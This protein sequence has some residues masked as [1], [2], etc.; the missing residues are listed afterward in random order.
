MTTKLTPLQRAFLTLEETRSRLADVEASQREPIAIVGIGCRF[1]GSASDPQAYWT[2]LD[3]E[4][5]AVSTVPVT[6]WNHAPYLDG[7]STRPGTTY[8]Q[9]AGFLAMPV[10]EFDAAFFG[11]SPREA[12]AMDPQQRLLLEVAWEAL[13]HAGIAPDRLVGSATGVFVGI[14]AADYA[15]LQLRGGTLADIDAHYA[16][17]IA[18]SIASGRLS[19]LMGLQGPSLAIDTACSSSL[20][21][22]HL[23][24]QSLRARESDTALAAGVNLILSPESFIAFSRTHMLA[25]DGR[26]KVFDDAADGF[27]RG[28]GCGVVILKRLRDAVAQGDRVLAVVRGSAANQDGASASLTAPSGPAQEAVIRQ[29]LA[30][31]QLTPGDVQFVE[32]H[33]TGTSLG[34][35]IELRA[36]GAV[37]GAARDAEHALL[38]GSVKANVGHLEGAAGVA[39]LIKAVLALNARRVPGQLHVEHRTS[40]VNWD[41]LHLRLPARGGEPWPSVTTRRAAVSGFGFSGTNAHVILEEAPATSV[42]DPREGASPMQ[43]IPI[44]ARTP[45]AL[46]SLAAAY[47]TQLSDTESS[48]ADIAYTA[49]TGRAQLSGARSVVV[50]DD[51][52][53]ARTMLSAIAAGEHM[54]TAPPGRAPSAA[55]LFTG[56][57][58]QSARMGRAL[59]DAHPVFRDAIDASAVSLADVW[60]GVTLLDVLYGAHSALLLTDARYLQPAIVATELALAALWQAWGVEPVLLVG[61]SLGEYA[62]AAIA[63]VMTRHD[64]VR[65]VAERGRLMAELPVTASAMTSV[66]ADVASVRDALGASL[67][68]DVELAADNGPSQC[69]LTG[70]EPEIAQAE[71]RLRMALGVEPRRLLSTTNAFHSRFVEPMLDAF[72]AAAS[73]IQYAAPQIPVSW[74]LGAA[75]LASHDAP[76]ARYWRRQTRHAVQFG[77]AIAMLRDRGVTHAIEMGPHPV[78][79]GLV[80]AIDDR[81]LPIGLASLRRGRSDLETISAAVARWWSDGGRLDWVSFYAPARRSPIALPTY[82]FARERHWLEFAV[83]GAAPRITAARHPIVGTR[84]TSSALDAIVF[85]SEVSPD[86]LPL[87]D[88]HRIHAKATMPG[89]VWL[90]AMAVAGSRIDTRAHWSV[91]DL[92][93]HSPLQVDDAQSRVVQLVLRPTSPPGGYQVTAFSRDAGSPDGPWM[94]HADALLTAIA[95]AARPDVARD[96]TTSQQPLVVHR[97]AAPT[98]GTSPSRHE[99]YRRFAQVGLTLGAAFER[100]VSASQG[101]DCAVATIDAAG[102]PAWGYGIV[103]PVLVDACLQSI[104]LA[105]PDSA[106]GP[107]SLFMPLAVERFDWYGPTPA[108]FACETRLRPTA[109]HGETLVAD[110]VARDVDGRVIGELRGVTLKRARA[111]AL[112]PLSAAGARDSLYEVQWEPSTL[113]R[114]GDA[115]AGPVTPLTAIAERVAAQAPARAAETLLGSYAEHGPAMDRLAAQYVWRALE[116]MG[117]TLSVGDRIDAAALSVQLHVQPRHR[118]LFARF[119]DILVEDS[120]LGR[121]GDGYVVL[122]PLATA[123]IDR[124]VEAMRA[125]GT[126]FSGELELLVRCGE[127]LAPALTGDVDPLSLL[128][129]GGSLDAVHRI[130][131]DSPFPRTYNALVRDAIAALVA[132]RGTVGPLRVLEVGGGTG[133]T[134]AAV[135]EA[136]PAGG[137]EYLFT[138]ASPLFLAR[139]SERFAA[140]SDIAFRLFDLELDAE[141]QGY[142]AASFDLVVGANVIHATRDVGATLG[143]LHRLLA[144]GG[145][146]LMLEVVRPSRWVDLSFGFT[147]GWWAFADDFRATYPLL[148]ADAW[149]QVLDS[150]GFDE[151]VVALGSAGSGDGLEEQALLLARKPRAVAS[152]ESWIVLADRGGVGAALAKHGAAAGH[153]VVLLSDA[154]APA[155]AGVVHLPAPPDRTDS[156]ALARALS[157]AAIGRRV[158]GVVDLRALDAGSPDGTEHVG[159]AAIPAMAVHV[160]TVALASAQALLSCGLGA[161]GPCP[162]LWY[163]TRRGVRVHGADREPSLPQAT[164][165]GVSRTLQIEHPELQASCIDLADDGTEVVAN[166]DADADADAVVAALLDELRTASAEAQVALRQDARLVARV[167]RAAPVLPTFPAAF[168]VG[169]HARGSID[170]LEVTADIVPSP[171][172]DEIVIRVAA[173]GLNFKDVL[174]VLGTYPGDPGPVGGECAGYVVAVGSDVRTH[175]R[176][177]RVVALAAAAM[178]SHVTTRAVLAAPVPGGC[179]LD[180][181]AALPI[182][183]LTAHHTLIE[184]AALQPGER[185]LIH[186]GAGGVGMAAIHLARRAGAEIFATA[187]SESKRA[188]LRALGVQH[189]L[190]SRSLA[191]ADEVLAGT[192]GRGVDVTLNSL[193]DAFVERSL[194]ATAPGGRFL[195]IG[196]RGIWSSAQVDALGKRLQYH[197]VDWTERTRTHPE[198]I[199]ATLRALLREV[200]DG[201]LPALPVELF[202]LSRMHEAF[203]H[204]AQGRH[205]GKIVLS[206]REALDALGARPVSI[207]PGAAYVIVGGTSGIGWLTAAWLADRGATHLVLSSRSGGDDETRQAAAKLHARGVR[208]DLHAVDVSDLDAVRTMLAAVREVSPIRGVIQ[209]AGLLDDGAVLQLDATRVS[210]V[211]APK[212]AGS[213]NLHLL[214]ADDPLDFFVGYASVAGMLG[215][216]GQANHA[217]ANAFIDALAHA[218][219]AQ[220]RPAVSIDW[221]AWGEIG[222]AVRHG[223]L[224][225]A[226]GAGVRSISPADGLSFLEQIFTG[227]AAQIAALPV[228]WT[229]YLASRRGAVPALLERMMPRADSNRAPVPTTSGATVAE[230]SSTLM[231]ELH[232]TVAARRPSVL[233][234]YLR[235]RVART[236]G[237]SNG[238]TVDDRQPLR[239]A[240]LDSLLAIEL[241]NVLGQAVARSL[242]ATLLFDYPTIDDLAT[243]LLALL[244]PA[245]PGATTSAE[246]APAESSASLVSDVSEMSD[247]DVDRLLAAKRKGWS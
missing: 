160:T 162:R 107:A 157:L 99:V 10:D 51:P 111:G 41:A 188:Y 39:S 1:P 55:F 14:P 57:G 137:C 87:L 145:V 214:T 172:P 103:H 46:R 66:P 93:L 124:T 232:E 91:N 243:H 49:A 233:R 88:Q 108:H 179:S 173:T 12:A 98:V 4:R 167:D 164:V 113:V 19:Y 180:T 114:T 52:Q 227:S 89:A 20:I 68:T 245:S 197:L 34:D 246:I 152:A 61:H 169:S 138:D 190:D 56:Q 185:V 158:T 165:W 120:A 240:G 193:A 216:A 141:A 213:W 132:A 211:F 226:A 74:N 140:R 45:T 224:A 203:R 134:T 47:A 176:G 146:L 123:D 59:Y 83:V 116:I 184:L 117:A 78:L 174:N 33:G 206:H 222:A 170:S 29:A 182:A 139:A 234:T 215:S 122:Q 242:P 85:E 247:D 82:P 219:R 13:E 181:A 128:F 148:P 106:D 36:L 126:P 237:L 186:A 199:G 175:H 209:S 238:H 153:D 192:G 48:L 40:H 44:A 163:V 109:A 198:A 81:R 31:A 118:Q 95:P 189:V 156:A 204:M 65:L 168:R 71:A 11:I 23:A 149:Q 72:E 7:T 154:N 77:E 115:M 75:S 9:H 147:E 155:Q 101:D 21:A 230:E 239:D 125:S 231:R 102:A 38:V 94:H 84:L 177:D 200:E 8:A 16:S 97:V 187:G 62:A 25:L 201:S 183:Y 105:V 92:T 195:E 207:V 241:R 221:G 54:V 130:Y 26:C 50:T 210:R 43:I 235:T 112:R 135:L 223:V 73:A 194:A 5:S 166:A 136:I 161:S 150:V 144:P 142:P 171:G 119:L 28:E 67:G 79:G 202:P 2:L 42:A 24:C 64:A 69:V 60:D 131:R 6:R 58:A 15:Q 53:T 129:P 133:G 17:G 27:V 212:V 205:V 22:V 244:F 30:R 220:G 63:G 100:I 151:I 76:D 208:V 3:E 217:A 35:P 228:D 90:E 159:S 104:A 110:V 32:A 127:R 121:S 225:R 80:A 236:L 37:Y 191:F 178:G 218:R 229:T 18:H 196:K 86:R 96:R 70:L 143:A